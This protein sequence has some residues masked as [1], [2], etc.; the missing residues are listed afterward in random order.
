MGTLDRENMVSLDL[1]L[2]D[3]KGNTVNLN[4]IVDCL[5]CLER[6]EKDEL[7]GIIYDGL[8]NY[9]KYWLERYEEDKLL[10]FAC[11][12]DIK[13]LPKGLSKSEIIETILDRLD[14]TNYLWLIDFLIE[15]KIFLRHR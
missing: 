7:S 5:D 6:Y 3:P 14:Y 13:D 10:E 4:C 9:I 11:D 15:D 12:N 2:V 1:E 8:F